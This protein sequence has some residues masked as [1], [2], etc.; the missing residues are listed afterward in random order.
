MSVTTNVQWSLVEWMERVPIHLDDDKYE[1]A[2]KHVESEVVRMMN[3]RENYWLYLSDV[4]MYG[5][6]VVRDG[7][8]VRVVRLSHCTPRL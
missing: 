8:Q 2:F 4:S 7:D 3:A 1:E 6:W 5:P